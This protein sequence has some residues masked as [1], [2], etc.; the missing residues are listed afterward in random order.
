MSLH[1]L[2]A[3]TIGAPDPDP[4]LGYYREF[5]LQ[6]GPGS[7][8]S[9]L[10]GGRQL[11][12]EEAPTRRLVEMVVEV[13]DGED[14]ARAHATL[15]ARGHRPELDGDRLIVT[16][17]VTGVRVVLVI[18]ARLATPTVDRPPANGP[19]RSERL[20]QRA[21]A[22]LRD[23][24]VRPRKLGHVVVTTTDFAASARFFGDL[25]FQV[26]DYIGKIGVFFRCS[27]DHHNLLLLEAPAVY[28]HHTAWQVDDV[29]EVGRGAHA[30]LEE[31]PERHVWGLGRHHAGSNFFW[32]LQDPAGNYSEY[33]ADLDVIP[34]EAPWSPE[35]H[36][37][38]LGLYSWGPVPPPKFL[39]P[40]DLADL[41]ALRPP[42]EL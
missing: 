22:V 34:E 30:M 4:L 41:I 24:A 21:P 36:S 14:L 31:H 18:A 2:A 1:R 33:Y 11:S 10:D 19:G 25:S 12:V 32:Y 6:P 40:E 37:G 38:S 35:A 27:P 26:S 16:E 3:V 7:T 20:A 8:L 28:L 9:T 13:D 23:G 29:D 39:Q 17:P 15:V 42:T 5:G